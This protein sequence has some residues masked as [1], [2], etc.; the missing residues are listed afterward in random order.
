MQHIEL[1]RLGQGTPSPFATR[2]RL[3]GSG[4]I[5]RC[6][7]RPPTVRLPYIQDEVIPTHNGVPGST[8]FLGFA[9]SSC[10]RRRYSCAA[11]A[12]S[13]SHMRNVGLQDSPELASLANSVPV[14]VG[15]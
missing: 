15:A 9:L 14:A 6:R 3:A 1:S 8:R 5:P 12:R 4:P 7:P 11:V 10:F 13:T 2:H